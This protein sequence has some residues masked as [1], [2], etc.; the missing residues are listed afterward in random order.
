VMRYDG[1]DPNAVYRMRVTYSGPYGVSMKCETDDGLLIHGSSDSGGAMPA[2]FGI[3]PAT[4]ADGVLQLQWRRTNVV[5]G[6]SVSE[7]WLI[8]AD[9]SRRD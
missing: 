4:T 6:P 9:G 2:E 7:I 8:R 5:R 3:P 1:L